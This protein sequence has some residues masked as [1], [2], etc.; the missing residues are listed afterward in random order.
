MFY[1]YL[2]L[3]PTMRP[4]FQPETM[5]LI[6]LIGKSLGRE[7]LAFSLMDLWA[8]WGALKAPSTELLRANITKLIEQ[9]LQD[10][11]LENLSNRPTSP[12]PG[13]ELP[14]HWQFIFISTV[15]FYFSQKFYEQKWSFYEL[16]TFFRENSLQLC[17]ICQR[18]QENQP[19]KT[20]KK[21][22]SLRKKVNLTNVFNFK[23]IRED[24]EVENS[25]KAD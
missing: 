24:L 17:S 1:L 13:P 14:R 8:L 11:R 9:L 3:L 25:L 7:K 10:T 6:P 15:I 21:D 22:G 23:I 19:W 4:C 16:K 5:L 12:R 20:T 2:S 18:A